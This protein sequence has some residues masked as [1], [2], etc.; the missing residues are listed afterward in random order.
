MKKIFL[1]SKLC[2]LA[3]LFFSLSNVALAQKADA[4]EMN[5]NG[6]K[7][8]V[9]PSGNQILEI[10][11]IIKGGVQN[12]AFEKQGIESLAMTAL[13]E[14][15]NKSDNKNSFKDKLDKV[16]AKVY[17]SASKNYSTIS[18]NCISKD[19]ENVW[20][21]YANAIT[22]PTFETK[23]FDR[24]KQD[25]IN[26]LRAQESQPDYAIGNMATQI[27]FAG[28]NN[29]KRPEGTVATLSKITAE[30]A[31]NYYTSVCTKSRM[32]IVVVGE[33]DKVLLEQKIS[34]ML[35][36]I[37]EG[38]PFLLKKETIAP[39]KNTFS[40]EKKDLATNYIQG[41]ASA[42]TP[43]S[44]DFNAFNLAMRI[45]SQRHFLEIRTKNGLSYAP[46]SWFDG[47]ASPSANIS[48]STT[49]PNKYITIAKALIAKTKKE[50]FTDDELKNMK[51]QYLT[52]FFYRQ[53]TNNAQANS[54]A[55]NEILHNNWKRALTLSNDVKSVSVEEINA[56]FKKYMSNIVWAYQGNPSKANATLFT[57]NATPTIPKSKVNTKKKG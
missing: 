27:A 43:G 24:I 51:T 42:P 35:S 54:L 1:Y 53:E 25:A 50:G 52:S 13:T 31:K 17:A 9:Q 15:G 30:D 23:E 22:T 37:P 41:I 49:E 12:Y 55:A 19:F 14:C 26:G 38:N 56:A 57:G 3:L 18:M 20:P 39:L 47:G 11:T 40:A 7:V 10:Q 44:V 4:F 45:F 2:L 16:S 46:G 6:V 28:K 33:I 32:L 29:A 5:V 8:I 48:V 21:L 34:T 36:S